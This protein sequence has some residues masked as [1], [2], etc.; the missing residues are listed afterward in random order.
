[1]LNTVGKLNVLTL[2]KALVHVVLEAAKSDPDLTSD[3]SNCEN[4]VEIDK[5]GEAKIL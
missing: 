3:K 4:M 2:L 1:M 5:D